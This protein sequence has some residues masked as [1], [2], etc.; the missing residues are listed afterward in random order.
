[1][2]SLWKSV[3]RLIKK[4][5]ITKLKIALYNDP[6]IQFLGIDPKEYKSAYKNDTWTSTFMAALFIIAKLPNQSRFTTTNNL[7]SFL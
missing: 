7:N 3:V 1:V 5:R 2:P 4:K 6:A